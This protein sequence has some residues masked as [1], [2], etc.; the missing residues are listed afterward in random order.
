M[1]VTCMMTS[2]IMKVMIMS[3]VLVRKY[4]RALTLNIITKDKNMI[5]IITAINK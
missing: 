3:V 1:M 5:E 2:A 4:S